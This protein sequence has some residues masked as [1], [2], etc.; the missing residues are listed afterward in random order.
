MACIIRGPR[1][2]AGVMAYPVG[3]PR[4]RPMV[5][6]SR[7]TGRAESDP[8]PN[9][10]CCPSM[11]MAC[12]N[13]P[14]MEV[15]P[16]LPGRTRRKPANNGTD[17]LGDQIRSGVADGGTGGVDR[18]AWRT[19][20]GCCEVV[21][22]GQPIPAGRRRPHPSTVHRCTWEPWPSRIVRPLQRPTVTAGL[23]CAP[24][25]LAGHINRGKYR[26]TPTQGVMTPPNPT[27]VV[28]FWVLIQ[29]PRWQPRRYPMESRDGGTNEF[30]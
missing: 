13:S 8:S 4:L 9:P 22:V 1:S 12:S 17:D 11:V 6:T 2:R 18:P 20:F 27:A 24:A 14:S 29:K 26:H 21:F 15:K 25:E 7:P 16:G 28:A 3:P 30:T 10:T 23:I 19:I 5:S